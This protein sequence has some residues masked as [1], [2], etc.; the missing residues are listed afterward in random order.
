VDH[1]ASSVL[2]VNFQ[3]RSSTPDVIAQLVATQQIQT[4]QS[5]CHVR[6]GC[7]GAMTHAGRSVL[8]VSQEDGKRL[9]E[10]LNVYVRRLDMWQVPTRL[11][12][13]DA[14]LVLTVTLHAEASAKGAATVCSQH[15]PNRILS[16]SA[17]HVATPRTR[18]R[19]ERY[20]VL[21]EPTAATRHAV[22]YARHVNLVS[23]K[24]ILASLSVYVQIL[25][26]CPLRARKVK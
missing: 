9:K 12:R 20:L 11:Q 26:L 3:M 5:K 24:T 6:L 22:A 18:I 17:L 7:M 16:A 13:T 21:L 25:V 14:K 10:H 23:G 8:C 4:G 1:S 15:Q 2:L 19:L